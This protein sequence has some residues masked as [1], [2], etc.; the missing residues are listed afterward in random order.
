MYKRQE[1]RSI[2]GGFRQLTAEGKILQEDI[3]IITTRIPSLIPLMEE[4]FGGTRAEDVRRYYES[5]GRADEQAQLFGEHLI[6][7][8]QEL[9]QVGE[10]AGNALENLADTTQ[11]VAALIGTQLL[12][13]VR[14]IAQNAE[15][16]LGVIEESEGLQRT[17]GG[18][19]VFAGAAGTVATFGTVIAALAP[20]LREVAKSIGG[21]TGGIIAAV[22]VLVG[23]IS[24]L[25]TLTRREVVELPKLSNV[26]DL[27][28]KAMQLMLSLYENEIL[29]RN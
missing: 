12:P 21:R 14:E 20:K 7:L 19:G 9:P 15:G 4:A 8:L 13:A 10:T 22:S 17:I 16:L 5:I 29:R 1:L 27:N 2:A 25:Y 6:D 28:T 11:R 3:A 26:L 23:G 24:L 18:A